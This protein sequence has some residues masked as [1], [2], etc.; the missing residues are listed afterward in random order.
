M[1]PEGPVHFGELAGGD[2]MVFKIKHT[3]QAMQQAWAEL[4]PLLHARG[5][6]MEDKPILERY[7]GEMIANEVC[8]ICVPIQ[9]F[10]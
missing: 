6:Q 3:A 8:E 2:Y 9:R 5:Y 10:N 1:S 4:V 7:T